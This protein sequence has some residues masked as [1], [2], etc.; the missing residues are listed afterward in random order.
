LGPIGSEGTADITLSSDGHAPSAVYA[1]P[2]GAQLSAHIHFSYIKPKHA[3]NRE[4][5]GQETS[6]GDIF[7][8]ASLLKYP[9]SEEGT[10]LY[11]KLEE[12]EAEGIENLKKQKERKPMG[13]GIGAAI[14]KQL[15]AMEEKGRDKMGTN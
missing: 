11:N 4:F 13:A 9:Q 10:K 15:D 5:Y 12:L 1:H 6:P 14:G 7:Q 8:N 2:T 3:V